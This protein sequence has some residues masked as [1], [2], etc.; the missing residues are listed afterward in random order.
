V[1][2]GV[3]CARPRE[4]RSTVTASP[5]RRCKRHLNE[6]PYVRRTVIGPAPMVKTVHHASVAQ[7]AE[8]VQN[9]PSQNRSARGRHQKERSAGSEIES[10]Q[11]SDTSYRE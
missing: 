7:T 9:R 1:R 3:A 11:D 2:A 6:T 4:H 10:R 8:P 5:V